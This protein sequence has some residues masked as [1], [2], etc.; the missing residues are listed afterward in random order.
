MSKRRYIRL[1]MVLLVPSV[2]IFSQC[3]KQSKPADPRGEKY[4]GSAAC[5]RCH[6]DIAQ[7]YLHSAHFL[8]SRNATAATV[9]G[10]FK[11]DSNTVVYYDHQKVVMER[12]HD[13]L[14]QALYTNGKLTTRK[15]FDIIFGANRGETYLTWDGPEVK[16]LPVSY[17]LSLHKWA[18]SPG[19]YYADSVNFSRVIHERCFECH[20]SNIQNLNGETAA[21]EQS[22][23]LDK[24]SLILGIDCERCHGPGAEHVNFQTQNPTVMQARYITRFATLSRQQRIDF[25]SMCHSGN[26]NVMTKTTFGFKPGDTLANYTSGS[27]TH[28]YRDVTTIDVHGNQVKLLM[29]SKCY[30]SSKIECATCH[31][32]HNNGLKTVA[33]YSTNC[34]NCHST[35][36]HN[37]CKLTDK[38]GPAITTNCIDCHMPVKSSKAVV[39]NGL[40]NKSTPPFLARTHLIAIYPDETKKVM[41]MLSAKQKP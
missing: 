20:A 13:S 32:M 24:T 27:T 11:P 6:S 18:N 16:Q 37:L 12:Q 19:G 5:L 40:D 2:F 10:S 35:A 15:R 39:V 41:L 3:L 9:S 34:T 7:N 28:A 22:D 23:S 1:A 25:C 17:Y 29:S 30:I 36:N 31:S 4:A 26:S 21:N 38:I 8:T 14:F 33:A